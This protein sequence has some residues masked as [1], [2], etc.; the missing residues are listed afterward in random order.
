MIYTR[1]CCICNILDEKR[2]FKSRPQYIMQ[3]MIAINEQIADPPQN[4]PVSEWTLVRDIW[5]LMCQ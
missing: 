2:D 3:F 4:V 1:V 5:L